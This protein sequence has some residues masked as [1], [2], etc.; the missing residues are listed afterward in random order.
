MTSSAK[1][2]IRMY[3]IDKQG[4]LYMAGMGNGSIRG[5]VYVIKT[6]QGDE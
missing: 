4:V 1:E 2:N 3:N 5:F 6:L